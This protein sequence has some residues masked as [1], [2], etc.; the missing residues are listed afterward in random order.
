M[1][2]RRDVGRLLRRRILASGPAPPA[3]AEP[4]KLYGGLETVRT[5][6]ISVPVIR[7]GAI[8]GYVL[9]QFSFTADAET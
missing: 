4:E 9:A 7:S 1:G 3:E 8:Q 2:V 5:R 6:M